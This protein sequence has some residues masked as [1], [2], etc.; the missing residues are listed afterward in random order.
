LSATKEQVSLRHYGLQLTVYVESVLAY[1]SLPS[2]HCQM[3]FVC[4][5]V[6]YYWN[7]VIKPSSLTRH[8]GLQLSELYWWWPNHCQFNTL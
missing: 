2:V 3:C 6:V 7:L 8:S 4:L 5:F 1:T